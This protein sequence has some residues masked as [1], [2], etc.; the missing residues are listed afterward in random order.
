MWESGNA[1]RR[2]ICAE[3]GCRGAVGPSTVAE[4]LNATHR[5]NERGY[6]QSGGFV[7]AGSSAARRPRPAAVVAPIS[8]NTT[9]NLWPRR[10]EPEQAGRGLS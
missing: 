10:G 7:N 9:V 2:G 1:D 4:Q 6:Y 8:A 5:L 3:R